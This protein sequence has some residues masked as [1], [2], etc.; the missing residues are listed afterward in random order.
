MTLPEVDV[1]QLLFHRNDLSLRRD[2][3][4]VEGARL[5]RVYT[6]NR[7]ESSNLSLSAIQKGTS[8]KGSSPFVF[9]LNRK[10][11]TK[12]L[13]FRGRATTMIEESISEKN[14]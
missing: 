7:I 14:Q 13:T 11:E 1:I 5:E 12:I 9:I 8:P 10:I 4:V 3:R 2:V 6:G